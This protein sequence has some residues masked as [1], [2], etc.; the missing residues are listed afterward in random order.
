MAV[1]KTLVARDT[2]EFSRTHHW[3]L[4]LVTALTLVAAPL[5][6]QILGGM[7][8]LALSLLLYAAGVFAVARSPKLFVVCIILGLGAAVLQAAIVWGGYRDVLLTLAFHLIAIAFI[9]IV[10]LCV[11]KALLRT[12]TVTGDTVLG[13]VTAYLLLGVLFAFVYSLIETF[14]PGSF[15][16]P[17]SMAESGEVMTWIPSTPSEVQAPSPASG[18]LHLIYFSFTTMTTLGYGDIAPRSSI[19]RSLSS[20]ETVLGQLYL[21]I[22]IAR[23]VSVAKLQIR[24]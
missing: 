3:P 18:E 23:L 1:A 4:F 12:A 17:T 7:S 16:L 6:V 14:A 21:A 22:L 24:A 11:L 5:S 19:A 9:A 20:V 10:G 13:G 8:A 15:T 2:F